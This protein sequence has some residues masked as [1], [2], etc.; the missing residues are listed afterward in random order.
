MDSDSGS[1]PLSDFHL[2]HICSTCINTCC[3]GAFIQETMAGIVVNA[4]VRSI[5]FNAEKMSPFPHGSLSC[6]SGS[7]AGGAGPGGGP[8]GVLVTPY[9]GL[10]QF[11]A[12]VV[13]SHLFHD[14]QQRNG[15]C[16]LER[17]AFTG[18]SIGA[19]LICYLSVL[20]RYTKLRNVNEPYS[21]AHLNFCFVLQK[22]SSAKKGTTI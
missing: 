13:L 7:L 10:L 22:V 15:T 3:S 11:N 1:L 16:Q 8:G 6:A 5:I 12:P 20:G 19:I 9:T 18:E 14:V 4:D 17:L 2:D 21:P